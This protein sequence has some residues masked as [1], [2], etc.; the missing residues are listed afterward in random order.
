MEEPRKRYYVDLNCRR[1]ERECVR[2]VEGRKSPRKEE[3]GG[4]REDGGK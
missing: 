1:E 4:E 3:G 2:G